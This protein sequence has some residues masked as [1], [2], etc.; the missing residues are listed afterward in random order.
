MFSPALASAA[1][2][3][4]IGHTIAIGLGAPAIALVLYGL[5]SMGVLP[6]LIHQW[7]PALEGVVDTAAVALRALPPLVAVLLFLSLAA[8]TWRAFGRLEGWRFGALLIGFAALAGVIL[9]FGL[10]RERRALYRMGNTD[11]LARDARATPAAPLTTRGVTP[12][13][14]R[15]RAVS[16]RTSPAPC[17][18]AW[19]CGC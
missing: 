2:G 4:D 17:C 5:I 15:S 1:L 18:R 13:M 8:E 10:A 19:R 14:P 16:G 11:D 7:R 12:A 6:M 9:V 3:D